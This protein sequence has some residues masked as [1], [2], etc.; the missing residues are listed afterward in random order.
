M[1]PNVLSEYHG[2][3]SNSWLLDLEIEKDFLFINEAWNGI[4]I[5]K[6]ENWEYEQEDWSLLFIPSFLGTSFLIV[7]IYIKRKNKVN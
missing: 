5:F 2:Q 1:N 6:L 7:L 4:Q 3:N